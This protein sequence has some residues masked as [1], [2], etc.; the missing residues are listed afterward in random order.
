MIAAPRFCTVVKKSPSSH[1]RSVITSCAGLPSILVLMKSGTCVAEW[2]PQISVFDTAELCTPAL[3]ASC[4]C[5][6][7]W[8]RRVIAE[9]RSSGTS[10]AECIAIKQFVLHGLP[11]TATRTSLAAWSLIARP[12]PVKIGRSP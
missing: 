11:T 1:A 12:W 4:A 7:F 2:L 5:A 3:F 6:R 10:F 8:S 9:K